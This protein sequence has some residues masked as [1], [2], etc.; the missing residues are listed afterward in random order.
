MVGLVIG[1]VLGSLLFG[2]VHAAEVSDTIKTQ[3]VASHVSAVQKNR[4]NNLNAK[5]HTYH[6]NWRDYRYKTLYWRR[7]RE[8]KCELCGGYFIKPKVEW[9]IDTQVPDGYNTMISADRRASFQKD[10][11]SLLFGDVKITQSGK[12]LCAQEV[13]FRLNEQHDQVMSAELNRDIVYYDN[14][15][16]LIT[17]EDG[18]FDFQDRVYDLNHGYYRLPSRFRSGVQDMWGYSASAHN[19]EPGVLR[20]TGASYTTCSPVNSSWYVYGD[21]V[22]LDRNEGVGT[23]KHATMYVHGIPVIYLPKFSFF[24][25][26][27]RR[28]GWLP[29]TPRYSN[30][31]GFGIDLPYYFN[32]APN[33]DLVLTPKLYSKRGLLLNGDFRYLTET[34]NGDLWASWIPRDS[35]FKRFRSTLPT[36]T[37]VDIGRGSGYSRFGLSARNRTVVDQHWHGDLDVNY[38]SD[39]YFI[40]DFGLM[41]NNYGN[42]DQLLNQVIAYYSATSYQFSAR[43]QMFQAMSS[44]YNTSLREQYRR[45][46]ELRFS[47]DSPSQWYGNN[48][49]VDSEF[50]LFQHDDHKIYPVGGRL[51]FAP[52]VYRYVDL[53]SMTLVPQVQLYNTFYELDTDRRFGTNGWNGHIV[54]A[55]PAVSLDSRYHLQRYINLKGQ[56]YWQTLEPRIYYLYV[57]EVQQDHIPV[58]DTYLPNINYY[59]LFRNNRFV[60]VDRTG[61][62]NQV[63]LGVSSALLNENGKELLSV[64]LGELFAFRRHQ[65]GINGYSF[66]PLLSDNISPLVGN[67]SYQVNRNLRLNLDGAWDLKRSQFNNINTGICYRIDNKRVLNFWY[68]FSMHGDQ[69]RRFERVDLNRVGG[70]MGWKMNV[71]WSLLAA[72]NYNVSYNRADNYTLGIE[73][74][75]C[76]WAFRLIHTG[77]LEGFAIDRKGSYTRGVYLQLMLK[78]LSSVGVGGFAGSADDSMV[79]GYKTIFEANR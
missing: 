71:N 63:A 76:C 56:R 34:S 8:R 46:P 66:D 75:S 60:G 64:S 1:S 38:V 45:I 13:R 42:R 62:A 44:I 58:F 52:R 5:R 32:L 37:V 18:K 2:A 33:Y 68:N 77:E 15:G 74:D 47:A 28:S 51:S 67:A 4:M 50:V 20:L 29:A 70:S 30:N 61:D 9:K 49:A 6:P 73:Y 25:D 39:H 24:L 11:S 23:V 69:R 41:P 10:G 57:P 7:S 36:D 35:E 40:R 12:A 59:Q 65:I 19:S 43:V 17:A 14:D 22:I 3:G 26:N 53:E 16:A 79:S 31:S 72:V 55:I 48:L 21:E 54:R 78:G 27:R